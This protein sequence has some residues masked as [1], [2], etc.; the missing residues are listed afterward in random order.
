MKKKSNKIKAIS[1]EVKRQELI[2][3]NSTGENGTVMPKEIGIQS[4]TPSSIVSTGIGLL[5]TVLVFLLINGILF[6]FYEAYDYLRF[7]GEERLIRLGRDIDGEQRQLNQLELD[8]ENQEQEIKD[9]EMQIKACSDSWEGK[10]ALI[11]H[12]STTFDS[13]ELN[14]KTYNERIL[15]QTE[16]VSLY[17]AGVEKQIS[18]WYI[19]PIPIKSSGR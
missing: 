1:V 7:G 12:Y 19:I 17:N 11:K 15:Q 18:R 2:S 6:G 13:Y 16:Q 10:P 4:N 8:I 3:E 14:L 5:C 9:L